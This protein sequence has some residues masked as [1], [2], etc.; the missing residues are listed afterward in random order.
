MLAIGEANNLVLYRR[1]VSRTSRFDLPGI[2]WRALNIGADHLVGLFRRAGDA[3]INL[4]RRDPLRQIRKGHRRRIARLHVETRPIDR[5]AIQ[6]WGRSGLQPAEQETSAF[7]GPGKTI[8]SGVPCPPGGNLP[9]AD[10]NQA[11]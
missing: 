8:S 6:P 4:R 1:A 7:Q 10:V 3:A 9:L 5:A 2:H 11:T